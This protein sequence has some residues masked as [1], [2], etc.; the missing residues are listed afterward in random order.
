MKL[1]SL[2]SCLLAAVA[3]AG[4]AAQGE[5][6]VVRV[7]PN[8][9][10]PENPDGTSWETAYGD[11]KTAYESLGAEG[12]EVWIKKGLYVMSNAV[13]MAANIG[14]Y[15]G[16]AG[17]E[18]SRAAADPKN[19][20][21]LITGDQELNDGYMSGSYRLKRYN[22]YAPMWDYETLTFNAVVPDYGW[23]DAYGND[24]D[25]YFWTPWPKLESNKTSS[26]TSQ[27]LM[28]AAK[29]TGC[30]FANAGGSVIG[31][32]VFEGLVF[33][34]F[35]TNVIS[36]VGRARSE[37][38]YESELVIRNCRFLG[39]VNGLYDIPSDTI[40]FVPVVFCPVRVQD[41]PVTID[42]CEF[43]RCLNG[44]S[45]RGYDL[46]IA[47]EVA[48]TVTNCLFTYVS[49]A[50]A[51]AVE[52]S[53]D[54]G[55]QVDAAIA[56]Q[57]PRYVISDCVFEHGY[58]MKTSGACGVN[59]NAN[60]L[61][62][63]C[64]FRD[65]RSHTTVSH[66]I[67]VY[68]TK[69]NASC[70]EMEIRDCQF[71]N[72]YVDTAGT[73]GAGCCIVCPQYRG[74]KYNPIVLTLAQKAPIIRNCYFANN[75]IR[76]NQGTA[77]KVADYGVCFYSEGMH[78]NCKSGAAIFFN[79]TAVSNCLEYAGAED[80]LLEHFSIFFGESAFVNCVVK[81]SQFI[82]SG[83]GAGVP[84]FYDF[85]CCSG[86]PKFVNTVVYNDNADGNYHF[87]YGQKF[88]YNTL[89]TGHDDDDLSGLTFSGLKLN[90]AGVPMIGVTSSPDKRP[91]RP[92][93][94]I[95]SDILIYDP[96]GNSTSPWVLWKGNRKKSTDT[97][98]TTAL[99]QGAADTEHLISD[100]NGKARRNKYGDGIT[101]GEAYGPLCAMSGGLVI[102][103]K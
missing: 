59:A 58:R 43:N 79:C 10:A 91:G 75:K 17:T 69:E 35:K 87:T 11:I 83:T 2:R 52:I 49:C 88:I 70:N 13:E 42:G 57:T 41:M 65:V 5:V 15:G 55:A 21:T 45:I 30:A 72:N 97:D 84:T 60:G 1:L 50:T 14:V 22:I 100:A 33:S 26:F 7:V 93:W 29:D 66:S 3:A 40:K 73:S 34:G 82:N 36:T 89:A 98:I 76:V 92:V 77:S 62:E 67:S 85:H 74:D 4:I 38:P 8:A 51:G 31:K 56:A 23:S 64:I 102:I 96:A 12:G 6:K 94:D 37:T 99:P 25:H 71:L 86:S 39:C 78:G 95:G 20:M 28:D 46:A 24:Y 101:G 9:E 103:L 63:R 81:D 61:V 16:F 48:F 44:V 32:A 53:N 90:P 47:N 80:A 54:N 68:S 27:A 19:N 18:T